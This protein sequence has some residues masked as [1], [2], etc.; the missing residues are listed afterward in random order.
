MVYSRP[1]RDLMPPRTFAVTL[2][3]VLAILTGFYW[4]TA[5]VGIVGWVVPGVH[6]PGLRHKAIVTFVS[7]GC[8]CAGT[9]VGGFGI[10]FRR[11]WARILAIVAAVPLLFLGM[12]SLYPFVRFPALLVR[13]YFNVAF[14]LTFILPFLAAI[15]WPLMLVGKKVRAEFLPPAMV[16]IYVNLLDEGTPRA[17]PTK[18]LALGNG[19]FELVAAEG[20]DPAV[21]HWEFRPGSI[22]RGKEERRDGEAYLL[23]TSFER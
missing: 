5:C 9:S 15:A 1:M 7:L 17:R 20:H 23:A 13:G 18:A 21:E 19:L 11:N 10:L 12:W 14:V 16:E 22:V 3:G 2:A 6:D 8:V 4:L